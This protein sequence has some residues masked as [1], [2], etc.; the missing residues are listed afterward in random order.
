[1]LPTTPFLSTIAAVCIGVWFPAA[2]ADQNV[3]GSR[4]FFLLITSLAL[5]LLV[6]TP[7]RSWYLR[8]AV[9]GAAGAAVLPLEGRTMAVWVPLS[10]LLAA[11]CPGDRP[12]LPLERRCAPG[13]TFVVLVLSYLALR[14]GLRLG[15]NWE[16]VLVLLGA[17]AV[18]L[19]TSGRTFAVG[20]ALARLGRRLELVVESV[21]L[22]AVAIVVALLGV[23][24]SVFLRRSGLRESGWRRTATAEGDPASARLVRSEPFRVRQWVVLGAS[25]GVVALVVFLGVQV[26]QR[27][28]LLDRGAPPPS[29]YSAAVLGVQQPSDPMPAAYTDA[30][31]YPAFREDLAW[32]MDERVAW[33]PMTVHRVLDVETRTVNVRDRRRVTWTAPECDGCRRVEV[34]MYGGGGAFGLGQRDDHTIA[35][36]LAR[37]AADDGVQLVV[38]NRGVPGMLHW[39]NSTRLAWDLTQDPPPDVVVFYEGADEVESELALKRRGLGNVLAPFEPFIS[40]LYDEVANLASAPSAPPEGVEFIGWPRVDDLERPPGRLAVERYER[41]RTMSRTTAAAAGLPVRYYWQPTRYGGAAPLS[42]EGEHG[43]EERRAAFRGAS[44]AL[45]DDVVDLSDAL[46]G[47]DGQ[48]FSDDVNHNEKAARVIAA[49][50]WEDL[51]SNLPERRTPDGT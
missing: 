23:V 51:R 39:R 5:V 24:S 27:V 40:D 8:L 9:A 47:R 6:S 18:A 45:P 48:F 2:R 36:E 37:I 21:V 29:G 20:I 43:S 19:A 17:F 42:Q 7:R 49:A 13:T 15:A 38:Q 3:E 28:E 12:P 16:P 4:P 35:S 25:A 41:S 50:M 1:M 33:R 11:W 31:W 26:A 10:L 46:A 30:A 22:G 32:V 34:W 44:E 14:L